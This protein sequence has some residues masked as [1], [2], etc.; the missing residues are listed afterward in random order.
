PAGARG[1]AVGRRQRRA[2]AR[3]GRTARLPGGARRLLPPTR[4]RRSVLA[5]P[6]SWPVV[7]LRA[8]D[9]AEDSRGD[10]RQSVS[11]PADQSRR[12]RGDRPVGGTAV[13]GARSS[14]LRSAWRPAGRRLAAPRATAAAGRPR[15][16]S[17]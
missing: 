13:T 17:P 6:A 1:V 8:R 12:P 5:V 2:G 11:P 14:R 15:L 10:R 9:R 16:G 7:E 3:P 4:V